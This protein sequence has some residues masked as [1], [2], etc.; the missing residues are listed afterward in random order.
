[1]FP[2][3][4]VGIDNGEDW[5]FVNAQVCFSIGKMKLWR[6]CKRNPFE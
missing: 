6:D 1:M 3:V 4:G 5:A 2:Y